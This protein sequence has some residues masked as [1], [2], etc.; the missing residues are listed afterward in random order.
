MIV[1][2]LTNVYRAIEGITKTEC[3]NPRMLGSGTP[4]VDNSSPMLLMSIINAKRC[5][6]PN[7]NFVCNAVVA[8]IRLVFW[9]SGGVLEHHVP[10]FQFLR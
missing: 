10:L 8:F 1:F 4:G 3:Q 5:M 9:Q 2:L 7:I 6:L